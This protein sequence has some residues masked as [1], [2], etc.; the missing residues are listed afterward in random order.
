MALSMWSNTTIGSGIRGV[1]GQQWLQGDL[2]SRVGSDR[3]RIIA[4]DD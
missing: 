3:G 1:P 4:T 2:A